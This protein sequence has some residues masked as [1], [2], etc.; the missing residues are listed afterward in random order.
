MKTNLYRIRRDIE[1]MSEFTSTPGKGITRLSYTDEHRRAQRYLIGEMEKAGLEVSLDPVGTVIG[2]L[3]GT[4]PNASVVMCGSHYDSVRNGGIF[5][6][7]SG[8]VAGIETARVISESGLRFPH[9]IEIVAMVEEEGTRFGGGL[10]SSRAMAGRLD[11]SELTQNTDADGVTTADAM[12][13]FGLD[14]AKIG[15]AV[16]KPGEIRAFLEL[17]IEQGPVLE[18]SGE[19]IG[20]VETIVGIKEV[21]FTVTGR[22]DHAGTTPMD[23]RADALITAAKTAL[24]ATDAAVAA[25]NGTVATVGKLDVRPGSFNIIAGSVVF[26]L[27]IRSRDSACIDAVLA[28]A[29]GELDRAAKENGALTYKMRVMLDTK[30]VG[31]DPEVCRLL[32]ESGNAVGL[33]SRRMLSGAGHDSMILADVAP[34]GLLFVPSRGVHGSPEEWTDY[35][36][37]QRGVETVC[38]TIIRL[39]QDN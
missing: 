22:A 26:F 36:Q 24:A 5:D 27:D 29:V 28:A 2:R 32:E 33:A 18:T 20:I 16:R 39:A 37:L 6:G 10:F 11:E 15:E 3:E 13:M 4:D 34:I 7:I 8:I 30:P 25:G 38:E 1:E 9:P 12:R 35:E 14:P 31:T 23:M 19:D 17:H 21:E